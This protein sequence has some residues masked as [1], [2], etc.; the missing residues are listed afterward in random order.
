MKELL[1]IILW[2]ALAIVALLIVALVIIV[3]AFPFDPE[4]RRKK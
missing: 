4:W 1:A 2:I 3:L